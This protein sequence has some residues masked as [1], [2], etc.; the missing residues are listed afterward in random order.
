MQKNGQ[1]TYSS[2]MSSFGPDLHKEIISVV[3]SVQ[4]S[5]QAQYKEESNKKCDLNKNVKRLQAR[6][7]SKE[8]SRISQSLQHESMNP[9]KRKNQR[10]LVSSELEPI[11]K[12]AGACQVLSTPTQSPADKRRKEDSLVNA[13][14]NIEKSISQKKSY[15]TNQGRSA[16]LPKLFSVLASRPPTVVAHPASLH[17]LKRLNCSDD[18]IEV[19][20]SSEPALANSCTTKCSSMKI[21]VNNNAEK[22]IPFP[23]KTNEQTKA[24]LPSKVTEK[25]DEEN[26]IEQLEINKF[27]PSGKGNEPIRTD[28]VS[29]L[30]LLTSGLQGLEPYVSE[31]SMYKQ[32]EN[33]LSIKEF[34]RHFREGR[35]QSDLQLQDVAASAQASKS[36]FVKLTQFLVCALTKCKNL[37]ACPDT[38][39]AAKILP[40]CAIVVGILSH[41][42]LIIDINY[43]VVYEMPAHSIIVIPY[44]ST[45][46]PTSHLPTNHPPKYLLYKTI[47][48]FMRSKHQYLIATTIIYQRS[49]ITV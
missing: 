7:H 47:F 29:G 9:G 36:H 16:G 27:S 20:M 1:L 23:N 21:N 31:S 42:L 15:S 33:I 10:S 41:L 25:S 40:M 22:N 11:F 37:S 45:G 17:R 14:K 30:S 43:M 18:N 12:N 35:E 32:N 46:L 6:T 2:L 38:Y 39:T 5:Y 34:G 26:T 4:Q 13:N 24:A 8:N 44:C 28:A 3:K 19:D 48:S 49:I